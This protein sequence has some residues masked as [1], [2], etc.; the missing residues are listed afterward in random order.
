MIMH[1]NRLNESWGFGL[2]FEQHEEYGPILQITVWRWL[3][4]FERSCEEDDCEKH[5]GRR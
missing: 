2:L 5:G 3:I 1:V 4:S